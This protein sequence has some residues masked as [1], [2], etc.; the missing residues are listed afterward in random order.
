[1]PSAAQKAPLDYLFALLI[2]A[3]TVG[4]AFLVDPPATRWVVFS[5]GVV[6]TVAVLVAAAKPVKS[7]DEQPPAGSSRR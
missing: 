3:T 1:M 6:M 7:T 4:T 5:V 2:C